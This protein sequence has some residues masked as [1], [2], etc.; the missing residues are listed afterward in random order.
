MSGKKDLDKKMEALAV[1][2][3]DEL[4]ESEAPLPERTAALKALCIFYIATR[5]LN[6]KRDDDDDGQGDFRGFR[7][8]AF[9]ASVTPGN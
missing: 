1:K 6:A 9:K 7:R 5:K 4:S 8:D 3:A 2:M